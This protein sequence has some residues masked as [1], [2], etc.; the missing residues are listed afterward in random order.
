[1]VPAEL[2]VAHRAL[3]RGARRFSPGG[4]LFV[5]LVL[6][7]GPPSAHIAPGL[8]RVGGSV[9][10]SALPFLLPHLLQIRNAPLR[11]AGAIALH[12]RIGAHTA[13]RDMAILARLAGEV[14]LQ[15]A[16]SGSRLTMRGGS[17]VIRISEL[18]PRDISLATA[19]RCGNRGCELYANSR[20]RRVPAKPRTL[21]R[22][23][24][25]DRCMIENSK[26]KPTADR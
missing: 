15:A 10:A 18:P 9:F 24:Y 3:V 22:A 12:A 1:M 21:R 5:D 11:G 4:S 14:A 20:P 7:R 25:F 6:V 26:E 19:S 16:R 2:R 8:L 13:L 23:S 17:I